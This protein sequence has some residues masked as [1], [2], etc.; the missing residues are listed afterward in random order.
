[1]PDDCALK[2]PIE[3][4]AQMAQER[5]MWVLSGRE[6]QTKDG[7]VGRRG[8]NTIAP[9]SGLQ[10]PMAPLNT[11]GDAAACSIPPDSRN[12]DTSPGAG[13]RPQPGTVGASW[14][15]SV[16]ESSGSTRTSTK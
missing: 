7:Q 13:Q 8:G 3:V 10:T 2:P 6:W 4:L 9:A 1:M 15:R 16:P 5:A 11:P 12:Q 14:R